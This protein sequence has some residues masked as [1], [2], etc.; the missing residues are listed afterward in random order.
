MSELRLRKA[1]G[2]GSAVHNGQEVATAPGA[3]DGRAIGTMWY[4]TQRDIVGQDGE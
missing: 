4:V 2:H 1:E 3:A